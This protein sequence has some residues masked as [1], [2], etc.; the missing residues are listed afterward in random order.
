MVLSSGAM[1]LTDVESLQQ[2]L[3]HVESWAADFDQTV[4]AADG[5]VL[6]ALTG[7]LELQKP[8]QFIWETQEPFPQVL[9][10]N[11]E[12][13]W[14]YDQDL[15]Q[16]VIRDMSEDLAPMPAAILSG[17]LKDL[18]AH[19]SVK[20]EA[21]TQDQRVRFTLQ[22]LGE[23]D[24]DFERLVLVFDDKVL[25]SLRLDDTLGQ[26]TDLTFKAA[27]LNPRFS[28]NQFEFTVPA[29]TDVIDERASVTSQP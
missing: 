3:A 11:G 15:E 27:R 6:Q 5:Q 19:F 8:M 16:V 7:R 17:R 20:Q 13:L 2:H 1:A 23:S 9:V 26:T 21:L 29:E 24:G 25:S 10:S 14:V 28:A 4:K 12:K 22:P 18:G